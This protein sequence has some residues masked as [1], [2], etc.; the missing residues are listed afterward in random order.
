MFLTAYIQLIFRCCI[1]VGST[2]GIST[3]LKMHEN[4]EKIN[5]IKTV[6]VS[7]NQFYKDSVRFYKLIETNTVFIKL[8]FSMFSCILSFIETNTAFIKLIFSMFSCIL[9]FVDM[10]MVLPTY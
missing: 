4:I 1:G 2:I 6:F 8:I 7:K 3:K 10:P 9:S 5:F